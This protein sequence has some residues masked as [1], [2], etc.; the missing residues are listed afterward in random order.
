MVRSNSSSVP[1]SVHFLPLS[2]PSPI[3]ARSLTDSLASVK[4]CLKVNQQCRMQRPLLTIMEITAHDL[5]QSS[6]LSC[7]SSF[8]LI[9]RLI[10]RSSDHSLF[11]PT[12]F[13]FSLNTYLL[14]LCSISIPHFAHFHTYA[15][16]HLILTHFLLLYFLHSD[17]FLFYS[18]YTIA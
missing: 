15:S 6:A 18:D 11:S 9:E 16:P 2:P 17:T 1:L 5:I 13:C 3:I 14:I 4:R 7:L 8:S 12:L 10:F